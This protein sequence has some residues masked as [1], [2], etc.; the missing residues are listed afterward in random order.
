VREPYSAVGYLA[1]RVPLASLLRLVH[2]EEE[3]LAPS[4]TAKKFSRRRAR[5]DSG[6]VEVGG[7]AGASGGVKQ[8]LAWTAWDIC[9]GEK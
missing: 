9:D 7:G 3:E 1:Q 4:S 8:E 5:R 6:E 2:P